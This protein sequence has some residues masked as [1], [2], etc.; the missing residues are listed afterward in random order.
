VRRLLFVCLGN[1]IR[2]PLAEQ[3]FIDLAHQAG[4]A[5]NYTVDSAGTGDWHTG[6]SPDPRMVE[7]AKKHELALGGTARQVRPNDLDRFD[8]ILAMDQSNRADLLKLARMPAQQPKIR[9]LREFD[10]QRDDLDVPD[11][12]YGG[13][14]DFEQTYQIIERSV[15]GLLEALERGE[16]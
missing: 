8:L 13:Q 4:V 14:S 12:W 9:M 7:T 10:P 16:V 3:L 1:I 6:E 15:R 11:P 2:S 5:K